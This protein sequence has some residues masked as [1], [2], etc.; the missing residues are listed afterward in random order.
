VGLDIVK[1]NVHKLKGTLTL[2]SQPGRGTTFTI[3]LPTTLAI[4]RALLVRAGQQTLAIPLSAVTQIFRLEEGEAERIGQE[5]VVRLGGR[6]Y[7]RVALAKALNF[8]QATEDTVRRPPV[9]ILNVED[10]QVALVVDQLL[11]GRELVLKGL[12]SHV[13]QLHGIMGATLMGD[14]RVVLIVNPSDL[15]R[16]PARKAVARSPLSQPAASPNAALTVMIVDDSP[17]VRRVVSNLIK[18]TGWKPMTAKDGL[19]AL[20]VLH[21][22]EKPPDIILLDI[23]MPRMDGYELL[24]TL[25]GQEAYRRLPVIFIT[26]RA[27]DKHRRKAMDLGASGYVVKPYQD[28]VLLKTIRELVRESSQAALV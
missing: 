2:G 16:E 14:G 25:K 18:N 23:E 4:M 10:R 5:P 17:S 6:V 15:L 3:R 12:G 27:G 9:L 8:K 19:D 11:G 21:R 7:P 20:E 24:A 26:S 28:A 22:A 1:A 13:R